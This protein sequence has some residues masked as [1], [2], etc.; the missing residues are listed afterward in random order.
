VACLKHLGQGGYQSLNDFIGRS[1]QEIEQNREA[2]E[3][4]PAHEGNQ[5]GRG[6]GV[7]VAAAPDV[8]RKSPK[9]IGKPY[10]SERQQQDDAALD[11]LGRH[12]ARL[13]AAIF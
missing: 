2:N 10:Q 12:S 7:N 1:T 6:L 11:H 8:T 9:F 4:K 3:K 13:P 5:N